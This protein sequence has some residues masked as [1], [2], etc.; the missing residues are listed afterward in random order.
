MCYFITRDDVPFVK[1]E[2]DIVT[3]VIY[4]YTTTEFH[5]AKRDSRLSIQHM[6]FKYLVLLLK[7][8][9]IYVIILSTKVKNTV[10]VVKKFTP[11][12]MF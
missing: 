12:K 8:G 9:A 5:Y 7:I 11:V 3:A 1:H 4:C 6:L 2:H 10:T